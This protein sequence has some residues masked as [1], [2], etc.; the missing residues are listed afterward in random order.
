MTEFEARVV[1]GLHE[2]DPI[3]MAGLK[4]SLAWLEDRLARCPKYE[5]PRLR[6]EVDAAQKLLR[7]YG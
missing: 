6:K 4:E 1:L 7:I 3:D 5:R 2:D